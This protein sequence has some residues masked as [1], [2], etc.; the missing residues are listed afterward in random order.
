MRNTILS[1][2]T[3]ALLAAASMTGAYAQGAGGTGG[4]G[5]AGAGGPVQGPELGLEVAQ[6]PG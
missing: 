5:G 1:I 4:A 6:E 3:C 2:F